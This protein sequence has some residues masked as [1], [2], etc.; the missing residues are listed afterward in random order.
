MIGR[1]KDVIFLGGATVDIV[2]VT[3]MGRIGPRRN[4]RS[5][6]TLDATLRSATIFQSAGQVA[7]P[8]ADPIGPMADRTPD[9]QVPALLFLVV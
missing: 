3:G 6:R 5:P 4:R 2:G 9:L 7:G 8:A 1:D